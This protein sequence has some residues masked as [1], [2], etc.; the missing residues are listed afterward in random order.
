[1]A[2][3]LKKSVRIGGWANMLAASNSHTGGKL[4]CDGA[5]D[6]NTYIT[7]QPKI[8]LLFAAILLL[9]AAGCDTEAAAKRRL[10]AK[11]AAA[12]KEMADL[13]ATVKD[14]PTAEAAR[15]KIQTL[16]DRVDEWT[17]EMD[18]LETSAGMGDEAVGESLGNWMVEQ[19]RFMQEQARIS[20]IPAAREGLGETWQELT[21]GAYDAGGV[22]APGGRMDM[23]RMKDAAAGMPGMPPH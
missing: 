8:G 17:E 14:K 5:I 7:F 15:P 12:T 22:F 19:T 3:P 6:M 21:G 9:L 10:S 18:S 11:L 13:L 20:Q 23:Q 16:I 4:L 1:M 2:D